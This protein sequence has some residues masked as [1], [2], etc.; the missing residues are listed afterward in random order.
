MKK[1]KI[2]TTLTTGNAAIEKGIAQVFRIALYGHNSNEAAAELNRLIENYPTRKAKIID[3]LQ[4]MLS[5]AIQRMTT[6]KK[7]RNSMTNKIA[8]L[9]MGRA[10]IMLQWLNDDVN[11]KP[12]KSK[13]KNYTTTNWFFIGLK[14][15]NGEMDK[16]IKKHNNN[17]SKAAKELGNETGYRPY[18][19]ATHGNNKNDHNIYA[20]SDKMEKIQEHCTDHNIK[21]TPHFTA[22]LKRLFQ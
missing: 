17:Y 14:F 5:D 11:D 19:S 2:T 1:E 6:A 22:A 3:S 10:K 9:N 21:P 8:A 15:A 18:I 12:V 16:L 13:R 4:K 20:S 7:S